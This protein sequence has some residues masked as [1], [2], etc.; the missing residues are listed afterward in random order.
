MQITSELNAL[1][2]TAAEAVCG[3]VSAATRRNFAVS[4][5]N[6]AVTLRA[7]RTGNEDF[8]KPA[9]S[10]LLLRTIPCALSVFNNTVVK[11]ELNS[12]VCQQVVVFLGLVYGT[13]HP[14]GLSGRTAV[15]L[16]NAMEAIPHSFFVLASHGRKEDVRCLL[17][18]LLL[19]AGGPADRISPLPAWR[20]LLTLPQHGWYQ[21]RS[22]GDHF[23]KSMRALISGWVAA[24]AMLHTWN[25][26]SFLDIAE[27]LSVA[28]L[29]RI[30]RSTRSELLTLSH[31]LRDLVELVVSAPEASKE[32]L[33]QAA[34]CSGVLKSIAETRLQ[35][36]QDLFPR[37]VE[38]MTRIVQD[39]EV[40]FRTFAKQES[41]EDFHAGD[42]PA[43]TVAFLTFRVVTPISESLSTLAL[44]SLCAVIGVLVACT[45]RTNDGQIDTSVFRGQLKWCVGSYS[46]MLGNAYAAMQNK[47]G[48]SPAELT[49]LQ[50]LAAEDN[51]SEAVCRFVLA[52][53][54]KSESTPRMAL[55]FVDIL[56]LLQK[57]ARLPFESAM[58]RLIPLF[59]FEGAVLQSLINH[60]RTLLYLC[61]SSGEQ[62][63]VLF[64]LQAVCLS[65]SRRSESEDWAPH[66]TLSAIAEESTDAWK[67][68]LE[69][70]LR[71][72][73]WHVR[74]E[75]FTAGCVECLREVI[76][77]GDPLL[78]AARTELIIDLPASL[79]EKYLFG[80]R[81]SSQKVRLLR[82]ASV[83]DAVAKVSGDELVVKKCIDNI[84]RSGNRIP[85]NNHRMVCALLLR[86][87]G[88][89]HVNVLHAV[90]EGITKFIG[91]N[92]SRKR[93]FL[94]TIRIAVLGADLMRKSTCVLWLLDL[95]GTHPS[96]SLP[97]KAKAIRA[98]M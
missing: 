55:G 41:L 39:N 33:I 78:Q 83:L 80:V 48:W 58:I 62:A 76:L 17:N 6:L 30:E 46:V 45:A 18:A 97:G 88:R 40:S 63:R 75:A 92:E 8:D 95:F 13:P 68:F 14:D 89:C 3:L 21:A 67:R 37:L 73:F 19:V 66:S 52:T 34:F 65:L 27:A 74:D 20:K 5:N 2:V 50:S 49:R 64:L 12:E 35:K 82:V 91:P 70:V 69:A 43:L 16:R 98:K 9:V 44:D 56:S 11:Y 84:V 4:L 25:P 7:L 22:E 32:H 54:V 42:G 26:V 90:M 28:L 60:S 10:D 59:C 24:D 36:D 86:F 93:L 94:P 72:M 31:G 38:E 15:G 85:E 61:E 51:P 23:L 47:K 87:M 77:C 71:S 96:S 81:V 79:I 57:N 53:A 29:M 1:S